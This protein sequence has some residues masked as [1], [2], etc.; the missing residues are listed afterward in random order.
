MAGRIAYY[1][2]TVTNGLVLSLDAAK[3]DSYPGS[4]TAWRDISGNGINGTL[5]NGPTFN[6]DNGGSIVFDGVDDYVNN[7]NITNSIVNQASLNIWIYTSQTESQY[8]N[9]VFSMSNFSVWVGGTFSSANIAAK[10]IGLA[11]NSLALVSSAVPNSFTTTDYNK[12]NNI[13]VVYDSTNGASIY[14]N[15]VLLSMLTNN[16]S[17]SLSSS[18]SLN[19]GRRND[20]FWYWNGRVSNVQLYNRALSAQEVLQ[21]YNAVKSRYGL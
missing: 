5:T 17:G 9:Y 6:S 12:W 18:L 2:N 10:S 1:G 20:D 8:I 13:C 4:G 3:R 16:A 7:G 21:N 11:I 19:I 14:K 15:T